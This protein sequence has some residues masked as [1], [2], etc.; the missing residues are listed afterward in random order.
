MGVP[1][2]GG[3]FVGG[4]P[5]RDVVAAVGADDSAGLVLVWRRLWG[6][7]CGLWGGVWGHGGGRR[8]GGR[9]DAYGLENI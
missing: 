4:I 9:E 8:G 1:V 7:V 3:E 5:D 2:V 6:V